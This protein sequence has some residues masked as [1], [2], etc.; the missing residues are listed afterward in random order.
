MSMGEWVLIGAA[1]VVALL[2]GWLWR[3]SVAKAV[4]LEQ[5]RDGLAVERGELM[6]QLARASQTRRKQSEELASLKKRAD[7]AKKRTARTEKGSP[8]LP[9]GTASRLTDLKEQVERAE[10][11]RDRSRGER[12]Q[13][14]TQVATLEARLQVS[15]RAVSAASLT[16]KPVEEVSSEAPRLRAELAEAVERT[17]KLMEERRLA[18]QTEARMRKR[19]GNQEQ[20]YASLRSELDAKKDRIRAQEER[21]QRLEALEVV[22]SD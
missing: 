15:V 13:L 12:E 7:K 2:L 1:A 18:K 8:D 22:V 19:M 5:A 14:A 4:E 21:I 16:P 10:R 11:E 17:S 3:S 9:L 20:L 6:A